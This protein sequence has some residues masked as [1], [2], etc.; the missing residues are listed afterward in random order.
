M[1]Q[2]IA[3]SDLKATVLAAVPFA[4][5]FE[6]EPYTGPSQCWNGDLDFS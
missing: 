5:T 2:I 3:N 1:P 4:F 6:K